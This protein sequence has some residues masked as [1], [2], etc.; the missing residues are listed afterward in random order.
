[1][2]G[3]N[4]PPGRRRR[5][6]TGTAARWHRWLAIALTAP[7]LAWIVSSAVMWVTTLD[8]Q[9][10]LAGIQ[11]YRLEPH[12]SVDQPLDEGVLPPGRIL[13]SASAEHGV[14]RLHWLRLASRGEDLVYVVKPDPFSRALTFDAR[15]GRRMD[16]LP[17]SLLRRWADEELVGTFATE[18]VGVREYNRY[19]RADRIPAALIH[20]EGEQATQLVLSRDEGRTLRR[21]DR[22]AQR[23]TWWYQALHVFQWSDHLL[24][25]TTF[26][27]LLGAATVVLGAL[28]L[29]LFWRRRGR[30]VATP[31]PSGTTPAPGTWSRRW[32]RI[33]GVSVGTLLIVQILVGSYLWLNLGPLEDPFRG[34]G[35]FNPEWAGGFTPARELQPPAAVLER[36]AR[37]LP[38]RE[39]PVQAVEWRV[40]DGRET[41]ILTL[42]RDER[43]WVFDAG[44]GERIDALPVETVARIAQEEVVGRPPF[45]YKGEGNEIWIDRAARVPT[46]RF[47]F[48]DPWVTDVHADQAT[49]QVIQRRP[50]IWRAF[51]PFLRIHMMAATGNKAVDG[52]LLFLFQGGL[53]ALILTGWRLQW[54]QW[55]PRR[56]AEAPD[57]PDPGNSTGTG[58]TTPSSSPRGHTGARSESNGP[59][60]LPRTAPGRG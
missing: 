3:S 24:F 23:F 16:P 37:S 10:G 5:I 29:I 22:A 18:V 13:A 43:E 59:G 6:R 36:T 35:S 45:E 31:S 17:D 14:E 28:G 50:A 20:M 11:V 58:V 7:L 47:R 42:R 25:W 4:H 49:G 27:F 55:R 26:L 54:L 44:T 38:D 41:W 8:L 12:N 34:K 57:Y 9:G 32:H 2:T 19:Y 21:S 1:M 53:L 60:S 52:A 40:L 33:L 56:P 39:R 15:S 48:E 46:Y 51:S 30:S